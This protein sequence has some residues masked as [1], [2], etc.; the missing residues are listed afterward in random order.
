MTSEYSMYDLDVI[1]H[2]IGDRCIPITREFYP[3]QV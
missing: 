1:D 2:V 3:D